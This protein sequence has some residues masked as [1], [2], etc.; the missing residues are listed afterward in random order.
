MAAVYLR[1]CALIVNLTVPVYEIG[2]CLCR[3][4]LQ[5]NILMT[6]SADPILTVL[7]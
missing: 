5:T 7:N 1:G 4:A 2:L 6:R 3:N